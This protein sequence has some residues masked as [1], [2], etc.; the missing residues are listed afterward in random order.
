MPIARA[1]ASRVSAMTARSARVR[2][3]VM[4]AVIWGIPKIRGTFLG[5]PILRTII[6]WRLYW[7]P[8]IFGNDHI[9][10]PWGTLRVIVELY[11]DN[12]E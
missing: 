4:V 8:L 9:G 3:G 2:L 6:V 11:W 1:F 7:G 10:T 5:V 12:G